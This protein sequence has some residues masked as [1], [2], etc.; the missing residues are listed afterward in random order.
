MIDNLLSSIYFL[1]QVACLSTCSNNWVDST[2]PSSSFGAAVFPYWDDLYIYPKTWQGVYFASQGNAPNRTLTLEYYTSQYGSPTQYY[3]F[4]VIFFEASPNIVRFI[5]FNAF[6][7]GSTA[8][9][10]IQGNISTMH[11]F[12]FSF[13]IRC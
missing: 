1:R 2:L 10:G 8:T 9:I 3:H 7:N 13:S 5:Y 12:V 11:I 4:Q 6:N